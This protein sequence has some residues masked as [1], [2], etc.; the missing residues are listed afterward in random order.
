MFTDQSVTPIAF[1][2][3]RFKATSYLLVYEN[4]LL[5][6]LLVSA[7]H[8]HYFQ[9]IS[10]MWGIVGKNGFEHKELAIFEL[11]LKYVPQTPC[12]GSTWEYVLLHEEIKI[13]Y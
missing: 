7:R 11:K 12:S 10:F 13:I 8:L 2:K 3:G 4:F 6:S 1:H 9:S 5:N